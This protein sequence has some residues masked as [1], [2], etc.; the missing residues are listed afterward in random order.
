VFALGSKRLVDRLAPAG[1]MSIVFTCGALMLA[2]L[3]P[4]SD[5]SFLT[6]PGGL[7]TALWLGLVATSAS[8]LLYGNGLRST[9][10]ATA[11]TLSLAEPLVATLLAVTVLGERPGALRWLGMAMI[12]TA[13]A[14]LVT[15]VP[16]P[17]RA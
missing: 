13:L 15:W 10:L 6:K 1:A 16:R 11:A 8:Y 12:G 4:I 7:A 2:P 17:N 5:T 14:L 9:P 3:I